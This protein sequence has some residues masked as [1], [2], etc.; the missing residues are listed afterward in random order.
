M[1]IWCFIYTVRGRFNNVW[2][3]SQVSLPPYDK[4]LDLPLLLS[5]GLQCKMYFVTFDMVTVL[6]EPGMILCS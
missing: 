4:I 6:Y 2:D 1:P 3:V 5:Y